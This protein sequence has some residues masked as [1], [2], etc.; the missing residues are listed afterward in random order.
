MVYL[1]QAS[2]DLRREGVS[3]FELHEGQGN[4]SFGLQRGLKGLMTVIMTIH[5]L[6]TVHAFRCSVL[7]LVL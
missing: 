3:R 2:E 6:K 1:F 7:N 5:I 4:L